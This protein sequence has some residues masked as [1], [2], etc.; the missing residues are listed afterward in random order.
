MKARIPVPAFAA[1]LLAAA[2]LS[3][4]P[5][6]ALAQD[7]AAEEPTEDESPRYSLA[8]DA[9]A[10][11]ILAADGFD[12]AS[13]DS[14][15]AWLVQANFLHRIEAPGWGLVLS[16]NLDFSGQAAS[17]AAPAFA[18]STTVYEAYARLNLGDWAQLFI[19]KRRM[20]LGIG[21]TF[22]PG[23]LVDPRSGFWDQKTGFRG[24]DLSASLG[25]DVSLR[26]ALSLDRNFDAYAAGIKSKAA[27]AAKAAAS[28]D[29]S[30]DAAAIQTA[31]AYQAALDGAAGPADTRLF[32][33]ALSAEAQL[34]SLQLAA[35]GVYAQGDAKACARPSLGLS[36]DLGG[37][38]LQAEGAVELEGAPDWYGT[39]GARYTWTEGSRMLSL[40]LDYD[41][42]GKAGL[43][44]NA[45]YL[46]PYASFTLDEVFNLYARALV[47]LASPSALVA[48][49]L[50]LYPA[51]GFDLEFTLLAGLGASGTELSTIQTLAA[52][53]SVA[54]GA[55]ALSAA[56]GLAARVHF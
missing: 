40:S 30:A 29:P 14:A 55:G 4:A 38:I 35:A 25:P 10:G 56:A 20:G 21:S 41:Y 43:L 31:A 48:G 28:G 2:F 36:I 27:A 46:L 44:K 53:P 9:A 13:A 12:P 1:A 11:F 3:A 18:P 17:S 52:L 16:H 6:L 23:D 8:A 5:I 49:G 19:G 39:A 34:G 45:H 26:A 24:I 51:R 22:A 37:I 32:V 15:A 7:A 42:N 47:D 54:P 50:T 33:Y